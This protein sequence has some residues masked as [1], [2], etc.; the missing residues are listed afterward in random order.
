MYL[1][2]SLKCRNSN[3]WIERIDLGCETEKE[4]WP[5]ILG[6]YVTKNLSDWE[7]WE[8]N[9]KSWAPWALAAESDGELVIG[10][11]KPGEEQNFQNSISSMIIKFGS[12]EVVQTT[13]V[14]LEQFWAI[15]D[16]CDLQWE[17]EAAGV[18]GEWISPRQRRMKATDTQWSC[19]MAGKIG[20]ESWGQLSDQFSCRW[21]AMIIKIAR[22][23]LRVRLTT[24]MNG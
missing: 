20:L 1:H 13:V 21:M 10:C 19:G 16:S 6:A 5:E 24:D 23:L 15:W 14:N 9:I 4:K 8:F 22:A 3:Q 17:A 11:V 12:G 7:S 18:V 2:V